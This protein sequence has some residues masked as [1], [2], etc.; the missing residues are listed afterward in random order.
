MKY[1]AYFEYMKQDGA[2]WDQDFIWWRSVMEKIILPRT[3]FFQLECRRNDQE[4]LQSCAR[5]GAANIASL[6]IEGTK[7]IWEGMISDKFV[8][9]FL[10]EPFD[11]QGRIKWNGVILRDTE[12]V[13][14]AATNH[15]AE[16]GIYQASISDIEILAS[17]LQ[18]HNFSLH[19]WQETSNGSPTEFRV[20]Y[21]GNDQWEELL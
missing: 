11:R 17:A 10:Q 21:P 5:M 18:N 12:K 19:C 6:Y 16:M 4:G 2:S 9:E 13:V 3:S 1:T 7:E 14:F 8:Y 20:I 15:G